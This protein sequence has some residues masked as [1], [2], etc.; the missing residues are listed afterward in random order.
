MKGTLF[1]K[2]ILVLFVIFSIINITAKQIELSKKEKLLEEKRAELA[3]L[4]VSN[5]ELQ[6]LIDSGTQDE[7]IER[8]LR[9]NGY[10]KSDE[11]VYVDIPKG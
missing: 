9:E 8:I 6:Q 5:E 2:I 1:I 7:L 4:Q 3:A 11:R 10:V